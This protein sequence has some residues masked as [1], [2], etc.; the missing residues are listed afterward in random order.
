MTDGG[1]YK[2]VSSAQFKSAWRFILKS[3]YGDHNL[4]LSEL[5]RGD[6][7][8]LAGSG[9]GS[10]AHVNFDPRGQHCGRFRCQNGLV[11]E[12]ADSEESFIGRLPRRIGDSH[13]IDHQ[14]D[15]E[16]VCR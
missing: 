13:T 14:P 7:V 5:N 16:V 10:L 9:G 6:L 12:L 11:V 1:G 2:N 3:A 4:K 8:N 15:A